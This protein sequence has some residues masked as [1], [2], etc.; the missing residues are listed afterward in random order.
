MGKLNL[1][2]DIVNHT[3]QIDSREKSLED[4]DV[5]L[6]KMVEVLH[7]F[8]MEQELEQTEI[9]RNAKI[10]RTGLRKIYRGESEP[11]YLTI[12]N[13]LEAHGK[14][15]GDLVVGLGGKDLDRAVLLILRSFIDETMNLEQYLSKLECT[16]KDEK[17]LLRLSSKINSFLIKL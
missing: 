9:A 12:C 15:M 8:K 17:K 10:S 6:A 1:G 2:G 7:E 3:E 5:R 11:K 14:N 13:I 4:K 16:K